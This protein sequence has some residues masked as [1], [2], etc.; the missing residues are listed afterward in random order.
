MFVREL[1][2]S[3]EK[4]RW[5]RAPSL[6]SNFSIFCLKELHFA[7]TP[8]NWAWRIELASCLDVNSTWSLLIDSWSWVIKVPCTSKANSISFALLIEELSLALNSRSEDKEAWT[9]G[10]AFFKSLNAVT[11]LFSQLTLTLKSSASLS[12]ERKSSR[13]RARQSS[14]PFD[15]SWDIMDPIFPKRKPLRDSVHLL[16]S[17]IFLGYF[18]SSWEHVALKS[19][20]SNEN[21]GL[22]SVWVLSLSWSLEVAFVKSS[23]SDDFWHTPDL[24]PPFQH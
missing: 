2:F 17:Y 14:L 13:G 19:R 6:P 15:Y 23:F 5:L 21:S 8:S 22:E 12:V 18:E 16:V 9:E 24:N 11:R 10:P 4:S 7:V 1:M 20:E 3:K